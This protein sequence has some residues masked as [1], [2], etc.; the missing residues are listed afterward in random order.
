MVRGE[1]GITCWWG[2]T[3]Q[4]PHHWTDFKSILMRS[5]SK[6]CTS[7]HPQASHTLVC[8]LAVADNLSNLVSL[9]HSILT[10]V[11]LS[12]EW[13]LSTSETLQKW[14]KSS[15]TEQ[16]DFGSPCSVPMVRPLWPWSKKKG[17]WTLGRSWHMVEQLSNSKLRHRVAVHSRTLFPRPFTAQMN[18]FHGCCLTN[19][20]SL[21]F[22]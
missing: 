11:S 17:V 9:Y 15:L 20:L 21:P 3:T 16:D 4:L 10:A 5:R 18:T 12:Y 2:L 8:A 19:R 22:L 6:L 7:P 13:L 14:Q 1:C